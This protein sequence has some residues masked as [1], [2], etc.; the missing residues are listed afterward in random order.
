V[1]RSARA[2]P[3]R[4]ARFGHRGKGRHASGAAATLSLAADPRAAPNRTTALRTAL[5]QLTFVT[6]L[7]NF[8]SLELRGRQKGQTPMSLLAPGP[9]DQ[10]TGAGTNVSATS[11][12]QERIASKSRLSR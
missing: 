2:L 9:T 3:E 5:P 7:V 12:A 10:A 1:Q 8:V 11:R 4:A 6:P